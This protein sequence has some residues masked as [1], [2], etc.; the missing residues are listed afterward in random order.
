MPVE[1]KGDGEAPVF[2]RSDVTKTRWKGL[3]LPICDSLGK[4]DTKVAI[5][6]EP[7]ILRGGGSEVFF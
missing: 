2:E 6:P 1:W 4:E 7:P 3:Y 5:L